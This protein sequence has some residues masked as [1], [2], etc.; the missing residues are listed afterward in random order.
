[1]DEKSLSDWIVENLSETQVTTADGS[2]F[3]LTDPEG[4]FPYATIVTTD[5][6]DS[7][8]D[9]SRPGFF[10]VNIGVSKATFLSLF[11]SKDPEGYDFTAVDQFMPH[12]VYGKMY[13]IS[14]VNPDVRTLERTKELLREAYEADLAKQA[15]RAQ[16][17]SE[18]E[19]EA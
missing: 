17:K 10:R 2:S 8:S 4:K 1:M 14:V 5:L 3:F 19:S 7:F 12:P 13:W 16:R 9:L 18:R 15:R 6:Y 11:G